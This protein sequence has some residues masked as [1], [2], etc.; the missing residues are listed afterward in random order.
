MLQDQAFRAEKQEMML[1]LFNQ[2]QRS[3]TGVIQGPEALEFIKEAFSVLNGQEITAELSED[4]KVKVLRAT[5]SFDMTYEGFMFEDFMRM[6]TTLCAWNAQGRP[7]T[8]SNDDQVRN[9]ITQGYSA[10]QTHI[11]QIRNDIEV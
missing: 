9:M 10:T 11:D 6:L 8:Q 2:R 4:A 1:K 7:A 5:Q 3:E